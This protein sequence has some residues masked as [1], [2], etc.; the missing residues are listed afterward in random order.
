MFT[1][2]PTKYSHFS[3]PVCSVWDKGYRY[4]FNGKEIDKGDEGMGGG[5]STY[6]YGFR[7]YN[8]S[9]GKFLS[10]DP[11]TAS[12][13]WYTPYQFA[14]NKPINCID[15]DGLEEINYDVIEHK[16]TNVNLVQVNINLVYTTV[17]SGLGSISGIDRDAFT[18]KFKQGNQKIF[19]SELPSKNKELKLLDNVEDEKL[20]QKAMD[21]DS[22]ASRKIKRKYGSVYLLDINFNISI[23]QNENTTLEAAVAWANENRAGRGIIMEQINDDE[24][25]SSYGNELSSF[26]EMANTKIRNGADAMGSADGINNFIVYSKN[27]KI[28]QMT[29]SDF[30][31][32]EAGHN[33][34]GKGHN[35]DYEYH[36]VGLQNDGNKAGDPST[37]RP[38][39]NGADLYPTYDNVLQILNDSTNRQNSSI[40]IKSNESQNK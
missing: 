12:Y 18:A 14:G 23:E 30:A 17:N 27:I 25:L 5:G 6:D 1:Q 21:G 7:I 35:G 11:L 26:M 40:N 20:A 32:H 4:G 29:C 34:T 39:N 19:L 24:M 2:L 10:V 15:L 16:S 37:G 22:K 8:P 38:F 36:E 9:M 13:P 31:V 33:I 28:I 3:P